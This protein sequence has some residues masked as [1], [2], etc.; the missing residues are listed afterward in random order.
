MAG[1][2]DSRYITLIILCTSIGIAILA[3]LICWQMSTQPGVCYI[4]HGSDTPVDTSYNS[5][6]T[7]LEQ[8]SLHFEDTISPNNPPHLV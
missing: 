3:L 5:P 6:Q 8:P 2:E 4:Q 1:T 7:D